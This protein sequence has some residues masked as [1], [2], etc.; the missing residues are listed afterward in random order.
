MN[1]ATSSELAAVIKR[2]RALEAQA[3]RS[4]S[5]WVP[6]AECPLKARKTRRLVHA[7]KLEASRVGRRLYVRVA[8]V[9]AFLEARVIRRDPPK[10]VAVPEGASAE[11]YASANLALL[12]GRIRAA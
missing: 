11:D 2:L 8:D 4:G 1:V 12:R 6:I 7:G 5:A 3:K 9:D 10:P